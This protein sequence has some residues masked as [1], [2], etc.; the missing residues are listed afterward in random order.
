MLC[1]YYDDPGCYIIIIIMIQAE[2]TKPKYIELPAY[3]ERMESRDIFWSED[4]PDTQVDTR[5][6][7]EVSEIL[8]PWA[9]GG[10]CW[11]VWGFFFTSRQPNRVTS[12]RIIHS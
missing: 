12:G 6:P 3:E 2:E 9:R 11:L 1:N 7:G 4:W 5:N 10:V 8:R